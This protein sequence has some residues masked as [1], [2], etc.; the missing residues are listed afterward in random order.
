VALAARLLRRRKGLESKLHSNGT[1]PKRGPSIEFGS[2]SINESRAAPAGLGMAHAL[3]IFTRYYRGDLAGVEKHFSVGL[4]FFDDPKFRRSPGT[5]IAAFGVAGWNAWILGRAN[6]ARERTARAMTAA[7]GNYPYQVAWSMYYAT[8]LR[9]MMREYDLAA[10]LAQRT[11]ELSEKHK[12][13]FVAALSRCSLGHARAELGFATEGVA[14]IRRG[15]SGLLEIGT[16]VGIAYRTVTLAAAQ[17]REGAIADAL[18]TVE[19]AFQ[20][21]SRRTRTPARGVQAAPGTAT[22]TSGDRLGIGRPPRGNRARASDR[23]KTL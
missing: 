15:I 22:E 7:N 20:A 18:E 16:S 3:Q 1:A 4:A 17:E 12:L 2:R 10:A 6:V 14:L 5:A 21:K 23:S 11:L 13:A 8:N 19:Q 9:V